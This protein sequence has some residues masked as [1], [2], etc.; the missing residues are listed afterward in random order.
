MTA[1]RNGRD[2]MK[3]AGGVTHAGS[4]KPWDVTD[5]SREV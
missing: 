3:A 4:C 5:C 1:L 2:L